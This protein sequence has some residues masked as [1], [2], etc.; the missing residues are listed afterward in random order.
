METAW[1]AHYKMQQ[2]YGAVL[3][4]GHLFSFSI[5]R[6]DD[7]DLKVRKRAGASGGHKPGSAPGAATRYRRSA[8]GTWACNQCL[9]TRSQTWQ[10]TADK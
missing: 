7:A 10:P 9:F 3:Y 4:V 6:P 1:L 8:A 5:G 2:M